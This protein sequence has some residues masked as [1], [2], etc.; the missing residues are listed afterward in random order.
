MGRIKLDPC[1]NPNARTNPVAWFD[2]SE[3]SDGLTS[4]WGVDGLVFVN[5]P[6]SRG[7]VR[8][9]VS[10]A[11]S[12]AE[13]NP[14][15]DVVMLVT[16]DPSTVWFHEAWRTAEAVCFVGH[17]LCFGG[18]K[19]AFTKPSCVFYWGERT[20]AFER[21]FWYTGFVVSCT[22][23]AMVRHPRQRAEATE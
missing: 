23:S 1:W 18:H 15:M 13:A 16:C 11:A 3:G 17:R 19:L 9:W 21:A 10:K 20:A 12:E 5:P 8:K 14:R 4:P 6:Y 2:G 22:R 7:Q